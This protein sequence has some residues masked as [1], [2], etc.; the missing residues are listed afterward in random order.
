M[1]YYDGVIL[2]PELSNETLEHYGVK[3]MHWGVRHDNR[4]KR[5]RDRKIKRYE[6]ANSRRENSNRA[7]KYVKASNRTEAD[8]LIKQRAVQTAKTAAITNMAAMSTAAIVSSLVLKHASNSVN[9]NAFYETSMKPNPARA[10]SSILKSG[11]RNAIIF[12]AGSA[13]V[14]EM[15][16]RKTGYVKNPE[17]SRKTKH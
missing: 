16:Y 15:R 4:V 8:A 5:R 9:M 11:V 17:S 14:N 12:G 13:V 2:K 7:D 10:V 6:R 3:G 1:E